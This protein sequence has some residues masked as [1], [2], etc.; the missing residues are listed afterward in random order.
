MESLDD[1]LRRVRPAEPDEILAIKQYIQ[2]QFQSPASVAVRGEII[3]ITVS[4]ASLANT[5][6]LRTS[7]LQKIANT[8]KRLLFRIG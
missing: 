6:R 5:L 2:N 3:T 1:V 8:T 7:E 4:S